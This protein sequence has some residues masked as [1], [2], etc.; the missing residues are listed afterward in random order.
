[1]YRLWILLILVFGASTA[2]AAD[3]PIKV[4]EVV[5]SATKI[6]EAVEETTSSVLVIDQE[7]IAAAGEEFVVDLLKDIPEINVVQNGGAGK[8]STVILRGG[9]AAQTLV[10]IDGVKV[11]STTV[12]YFDF[13]NL[14]TDDIERIEIVKGAQSTIYGSEAMAGVINIITKKGKGPLTV[15]G[16]YEIGTHNTHSP[17]VTFSSGNDKVDFR[18]TGSHFETDGISAAKTG[19]EADG[20]KNDSVSARIGIRPA[21]KFE[22]EF[23]GRY[24]KDRSELDAFGAD[25]LNYVQ[26]GDH[27]IMS[28]KGKLYLTD[29]WEQVLT[30]S[31]VSD[32]LEYTDPDNASRNS[33]INTALNTADWQHNLYLNDA[34]VLTLGAEYREEEG[35]N[36]GVFDRRIDN[37]AFYLNNKIKLLNDRL[38]LNAG[39]R[40]D[41]HESFG[42]KTT[43]RV[44]GVYNM[45][46]AGLQIKGN[47]GKGFRAP[48]LNELYYQDSWSS[49]NPNLKPEKS[50]SWE[51]GFEKEI[52]HEKAVV[53]LTYFDQEYKDLIQWIETPPGSWQYVPQNTAEAQVRGIEA[54]AMA[55][56]TE[57]LSASSY[58][59]YTDSE[60]K[61]TGRRLKRRPLEKLNVALDYSRGPASAAVNYTY[62][63]KVYESVS[64]GNL[65]SYV[66][67]DLC[68]SYKINKNLKVFGR[69]DN[70]FD[71]QYEV[72]G[73]YGTPGVS[74]YTG[75]KWSI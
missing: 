5:V 75:I 21:E 3:E 45:R 47:Y 17:S 52:V 6:E 48:T 4:K 53:S 26:R 25:D 7:T 66:L 10:M 50:T 54:G 13:A 58:Y 51:I 8:T 32:D 42:D 11:K 15:E 72:A 19:A 12:G 39:L 23:S 30:L 56:I 70:L 60:D 68:G 69:I 33:V 2:F 61:A 20:Y 35:E 37:T 67:V 14:S 71:E 62:V 29:E 28:G 40:Y 18:I 65:P 74:V 22:L 38:V 31:R 44:G 63:S 36:I 41:D 16:A 46:S 1:M 64:I 59:T 49:G 9:S 55:Q 73:G 34:Y 57:C 43:Y 27:Y 24:S